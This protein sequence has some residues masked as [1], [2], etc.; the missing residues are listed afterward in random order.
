MALIIWFIKLSNR[1]TAGIFALKQIV[2]KSL[3][4]LVIEL[5]IH[6]SAYAQ[7]EENHEALTISAALSIAQ[8]FDAALS[9]APEALANEVRQRQ[10]QDYITVGK[11]WIVGRPSWE[12]N[13]IDDGVLDNVGQRE[14]EAGI[15][16]SLK[17]PSQR[18]EAAQLGESYEA[19][20]DAWS[21]YLQLFIAGRVRSNLASIEAAETMLTLE[22]QATQ[23]AERLLESTNILFAAGSVPQLDV[24]QAETLLLQQRRVELFAEAEIVDA[25]REYST[26]TG[27]QIRPANSFSEART[28]QQ[29][30]D[31]N[32]PTLRYLQAGIDLAE[33]NVTKLKRETAGSP[34][35][36]FGVRRERGINSQPFTDSLGVSFSIPFG[37]GAAISSSVSHARREKVDVDIQFLDT[38]RKLDAGLHEVEHQLFLTAESLELSE[39]ELALTTQR[40]EMVLAAFELGEIDLSQVIVALQRAHASEKELADLQLRQQ[41]L[42]SEFNQTIGILP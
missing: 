23:D 8:V 30:I 4:L 40:Y 24:M 7:H 41:R 9:N 36:T 33:A 13:Y 25:E 26:L 10:A 3:L 37:G 27:L 22:Q 38:W 5:I 2:K 32:H 1:L 39:M 14:M 28:L 34:S 19:Q 21:A 11:S 17:R 18:R 6:S 29:V 42:T 15:R 35:L 20:V 16:L 12:L 31:K